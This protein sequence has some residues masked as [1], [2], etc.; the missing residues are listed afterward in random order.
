MCVSITTTGLPG[1]SFVRDR[2]DETSNLSASA[3][4]YC[5]WMLQVENLFE[6]IV[7]NLILFKPFAKNTSCV[8]IVSM[9]SSNKISLDTA[10]D[11]RLFCSDSSLVDCLLVV[12]PS[13]TLKTTKVSNQKCFRVRET[14]ASHTASYVDFTDSSLLM[15]VISEEI[16]TIN[17]E[18]GV[19]CNGR[20]WFYFGLQFSSNPKALLFVF[21]IVKSWK[22]WYLGWKFTCYSV[23][24]QSWIA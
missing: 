7:I 24:Q 5:I 3:S 8:V 6:T 23:E 18:P 4:S 2:L 10:R 19:L 20:R 9:C 14:Q 11:T 21:L 13:K 12:Y 22:S 1:D 16:T 15:V 17:N